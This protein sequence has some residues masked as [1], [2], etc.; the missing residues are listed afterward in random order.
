MR[1][2]ENILDYVDLHVHSTA[3]DGTLSPSE[4]I[5]LGKKLNLRA[6]ALTDHDTVDGIDEALMAGKEYGIEVIPG[7]ELSCSYNNKEIHIVG[8]FINHK[9]IHFTEELEHLRNTRNNRNIEMAEKFCEL[10]IPI[11]FEEIQAH[12]PDATITRAHFAK[13]LYEKNFTSSIRDGFDRYLN[14]RGPCYVT[15]YKMPYSETIRLIHE[16][17]GVAILAHPILYRMGQTEL[18]KMIIALSK[19]G[20]DGIEAIYS[21]YTPSDESLIRRF[22]RQNNLLLSGGSD[23]HGTNK[24]NIQLGMGKGKLRIPYDILSN[25]KKSFPHTK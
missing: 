22:A 15:R 14:D 25:I 20:L 23:F 10:G 3:S 19:C 1:K 11:S 4:V 21:T 8:L 5:Q 12:Y 18:E 2:E 16:A 24:P 17:G 13:Y 6:L 9:N 7:V